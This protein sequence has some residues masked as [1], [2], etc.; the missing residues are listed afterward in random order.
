[1]KNATEFFFFKKSE[2]YSRQFENVNSSNSSFHVAIVDTA[3]DTTVDTTADRAVDRAVD[4]TVDT[5]YHR[6]TVL[7]AR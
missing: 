1:V 4:T 5:L 3:A 2:V 6:I 7:T